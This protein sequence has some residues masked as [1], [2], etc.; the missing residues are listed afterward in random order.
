MF[1]VELAA[2]GHILADGTEVAVQ[3]LLHRLQSLKAA[4]ALVVV[5]TD[6]FD[7]AVQEYA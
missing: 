6:A 5:D 2:G 3:P 7:V 1:V 4:G